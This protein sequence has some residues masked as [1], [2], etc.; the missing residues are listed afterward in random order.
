MTDENAAPAVARLLDVMDRLRDPESGCPWDLEQDFR[1]IAP[2]TIEEAHEVAD[3][4]ERGDMEQLRDELGDLLF[5]VVFHARLAREQ[6]AF[7]FADVA[8]GVA[9]KLIRR[10]PHVFGQCEQLDAE[11]QTDAWEQ[12][13]ARERAEAGLTGAVDGV[14][15]S[16]PPLRR[17]A[18]LQSRAARVGF[19]WPDVAPVLDKIRE[20]LSELEHEVGQGDPDR[21]EDELGDVLFAVANLARKADI[22][23]DAALRRTNL[24]FERRFRAMEAEAQADGRRFDELDLD[25]QEALWQRVKARET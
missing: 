16:L 1:S 19:D 2:Y 11:S 5:Q 23:A 20:E 4:I 22:D 7:A 9:D 25:A 12:I 24:K 13:K 14:S 15:G 6:G 3:A 18:K 8:A 17:A 21:I 10:H